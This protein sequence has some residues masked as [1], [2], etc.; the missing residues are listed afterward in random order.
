MKRI[1]L[2][3]AMLALLASCQKGEEIEP[4][5][6]ISFTIGLQLPQSGSMTRTAASELYGDFYTNYI[7]THTKLPQEYSLTFYKGDKEIV[8]VEGKWIADIVTMPIGTY[9]VLGT[10]SGDFEYGTLKFNQEITITED[11]KNI[12]LTAIWDCYMLMFDKGVYKSVSIYHQSF[13]STATTSRSLTET[14]GIYY[15]FLPYGQAKYIKYSAKNGD[16]GTVYLNQ[17]SFEKGK[18]YAFDLYT[19]TFSVPQMESGN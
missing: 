18:Y 15:L 16:A 19:G 9:K 12:A 10:S 7:E 17:Y 5:K 2:I 8:S 4:V 13:D 14:D 11:T 6:E 1:L 3:C